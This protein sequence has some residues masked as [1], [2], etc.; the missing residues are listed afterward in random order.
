MTQWD[1]PTTQD[2][3]SSQAS[4]VEISQRIAEM[5]SDGHLVDGRAILPHSSVSV[6][7]VL[8]DDGSYGRATIYFWCDHPDWDRTFFDTASAW[9]HTEEEA[10]GQTIL[11]TYLRVFQLIDHVGTSTPDEEFSTTYASHA[12]RWKLWCGSLAT[13]GDSLPDV[14]DQQ[15]PYYLLLREAIQARLGNQK[16]SHIK[17]T[18][19]RQGNDVVAEVRMNNIFSVDMTQLLYDHIIGT[20]PPYA[21]EIHKQL[22]WIQQD[23]ATHVPQQ[24]NFST[25]K[26]Q[27]LTS[28]RVFQDMWIPPGQKYDKAEY[29][30]L[31]L[32]RSE[33][34]ALAGEVVAL[35][36]E[37][38]AQQLFP[39]VRVSED[40]ILRS[41]VED[42]SANIH[43]LS[44]YAHM[45]EA[46]DGAWC[47]DV[48]EEVIC[49]WVESSLVKHKALEGAT[50]LDGDGATP[51]VH[52]VIPVGAG[53]QLT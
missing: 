12:H 10:V 4:H 39:Q 50:A 52:L 49:G 9:G 17:V 27:L 31:V 22:I 44:S 1:Q 42:F 5:I 46:L 26:K 21:E 24:R 34:P 43:Q 11:N 32:T 15:A 38:A 53:Y 7:A 47:E 48:S 41:P 2:S 51:L 37:I 33:D 29:E 28:A 16:I 45:C 14:R 25:V 6:R 40:I 36:P 30:Q 23:P 18:A 3:L 20:W 35:A 13:I 8:S 19:G